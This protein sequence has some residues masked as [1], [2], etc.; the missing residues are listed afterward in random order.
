MR[1]YKFRF[2][3]FFGDGNEKPSMMYG[4]KFAFEGY[5]PI[6]DQFKYTNN[7]VMQYT[8]FK[9]SNG[10]EIYEGDIVYFTVLDLFGNEDM[11]GG[12]VKYHDGY[13]ALPSSIDREYREG[14]QPIE[15]TWV[16]RKNISIEVIG[17]IYENPELLK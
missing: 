2:F 15:L 10:K 9:D 17:N 12:V 11:G 14:E 4:D 1:E 7:V 5:L 6:N 13:F 16:I 3:G 8:G